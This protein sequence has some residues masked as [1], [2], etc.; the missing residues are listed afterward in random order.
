MIPQ[1]VHVAES[2]IGLNNYMG[3]N[4][5]VT[6]KDA[7]DFFTEREFSVDVDNPPPGGVYRGVV[8]IRSGLR[9][10]PELVEVIDGFKKCIRFV[11]LMLS[12]CFTR[13][14]RLTTAID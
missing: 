12:K 13:A 3:I 7:I 1:I 10:L 5:I 6:K 8:I 14:G 4:R 2:I 11:M 9:Q